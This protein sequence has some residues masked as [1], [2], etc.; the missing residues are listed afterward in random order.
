MKNAP[1]KP[2]HGSANKSS[3]LQSTLKTVPAGRGCGA[4]PNPFL[5][6]MAKDLLFVGCLLIAERCRVPVLHTLTPG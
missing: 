3:Q 2:V 5:L 6:L 4:K 1:L